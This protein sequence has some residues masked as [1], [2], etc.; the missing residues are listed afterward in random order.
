MNSNNT[1]NN[2]NPTVL[3]ESLI[4]LYLSVKVRSNEDVSI[5]LKGVKILTLYFEL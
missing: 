4:D 2:T 5:L 3:H 1:V